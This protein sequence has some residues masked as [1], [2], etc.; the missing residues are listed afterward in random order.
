MTKEI[1]EFMEELKEDLFSRI[2]RTNSQRGGILS[3]VDIKVK[4]R[5]F[6]HSLTISFEN[7]D[8][9]EI[10]EIYIPLPWKEKN[11]LVKIGNRVQRPV[12][13]WMIVGDPKIYSYL[14][15][16]FM[17]LTRGDDHPINNN[18]IT[19]CLN[20]RMVLGIFSEDYS[21]IMEAQRRI[22]ELVNQ[23][24]LHEKDMLT[25]AMNHRL[26]IVDPDFNLLGPDQK[27]EY[28]IE[29]S[30]EY[31]D[32]GWSVI[33]LS[34][35]ALS[36]KNYLLM[37]DLKK[38]TPF[39]IRHHNPQ[40]NLYQPLG[41]SGEEEAV[42]RSKS[43]QKLMDEGISRKG[44]N[45]MTAFI[46]LPLNFEDQ[47][48]ISKET[49]K[50]LVSK[51]R[52]SFTCWGLPMV[53]A[54]QELKRGDVISVEIHEDPIIFRQYCDYAKVISV[55]EDELPFNGRMMMVHIVTVEITRKFKEGTKINNLHGNKGV[56]K[57]AQTG[58]MWDPARGQWT[59][60]DVIV[61]GKSVEKRKNFGQILEAL[62][63]LVHGKDEPIIVDDEIVITDD[64][65]RRALIDKG[66]PRAGTSK[67]KTTWGEFDSIC[68]WIFW[69]HSKD[70]EDQRWD[71]GTV[72]R[73]NGRG[74]RPAGTKVSTIEFKS[75][76]TTFGPKSPVVDEILSYQQGM[77][78]VKDMLRVVNGMREQYPSNLPV[79][80]PNSIKPL[81]TKGKTF[82]EPVQLARTVCDEEFYPD[83][84]IL[85]LPIQ[86]QVTVP[87][88]A[89]E[90]VYEGEI[91]KEIAKEGK[92]YVIDK[93]VG[94]TGENRR[95]WR[96]NTG[97]FGVDEFGA[98]LNRVVMACQAG[99]E[100]Q[101]RRA[102]SI[103]LNRIARK[104][105]RK[106]GDISQYLL[107]VRYPY[108]TRAVATGTDNL[109]ENWIE[110]HET[111][112]RDLEV[113]TGDLVIAERFPCLGFMSLRTQKV[114]VTRD[115]QCR[116]VIR[117][118]GNS[119]VSQNLDFD[120]DCLYLMSFHT[121][122]AKLAL[123]EEFRNPHPYRA[124]II[125]EIN[126]KKVPF[127]RTTGLDQMQMAIFGDLTADEHAKIVDKAVG[128]KAHTGPVIALAYN[129]MRI[130]EGEVK[131][132]DVETHAAIERMLD[133]LGNSVFSQKHGIESLHSKCIEAVCL[134]EV[135][136]MVEM[137][138]DEKGSKLLCEIVRRKAE[139]IGITDLREHF[140]R[141]KEEG[142]SNIIN[143]IVRRCHK[144]YFATRA[145]L[146]PIRLLEHLE[147]EPN[148]LVGYL[149]KK[150]M[151]KVESLKEDSLRLKMGEL[152]NR[153]EM[154]GVT[155]SENKSSGE[156]LTTIG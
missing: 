115:P 35:S 136:K 88:M 5:L 30:K 104:L 122:A 74:L 80:D 94:L 90:E 125:K 95:Q 110:I 68:G 127:T 140:G 81:E 146:H 62:K 71:K 151:E 23:L 40:R 29:Q 21:G 77:G 105:S 10:Q 51:H 118:S 22:S 128:V 145:N 67:C 60:I 96:H 97:A 24:P 4:L 126:S 58:K 19:K 53:R 2:K 15:I 6:K 82:F 139:E 138:F 7:R 66:Y 85:Q 99:E 134:A 9:D 155:T 14:D 45:L 79:L 33:G 17:M 98:Y 27:L 149:F 153:L 3:F 150:S 107:A 65:L 32:K 113:K 109:P 148:D 31:F 18:M 129:L 89:W 46:D 124:E 100:R 16:I 83:G 11:G 117:V 156:K 102:V 1:S 135:E 114:R 61:S 38:F 56:I 137:G 93:I 133:Y 87:E 103:Y 63:T 48:I 144:I 64:V 92:T 132:S 52:R 78:K 123:V 59:H 44:W 39:G 101:I 108:S 84:F 73:L 47:I 131:Y 25:W 8:V 72:N 70:V 34:D 152:L 130:I 154:L 49:A 91:N 75:L 37:K 57:I 20:E 26:M 143:T 142:R 13:K 86:I 69:G 36:E 141:H 116:F 42:V 112:A 41:M 111:M 12:C 54:G 119:L 43:M 106:I 76:V 28:K 147:T 55:E 120:G 50:R 121:P